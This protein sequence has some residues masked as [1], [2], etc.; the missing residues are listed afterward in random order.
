MSNV[1]G[2]HDKNWIWIN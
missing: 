2:M 1:I